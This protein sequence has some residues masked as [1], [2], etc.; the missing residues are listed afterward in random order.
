MKAPALVF[1][2]GKCLALGNVIGGWLFPH[3]AEIYQ[4]EMPGITFDI[5]RAISNWGAAPSTIYPRYL[6]DPETGDWDDPR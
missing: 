6:R 4:V 5:F 1:I 2:N 3:M